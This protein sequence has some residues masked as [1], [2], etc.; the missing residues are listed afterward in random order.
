MKPR[1][2]LLDHLLGAALA[3]AYVALLLAGSADLAMSRDESFYVAAAQD[4]GRWMELF[5]EDRPAAMRK[6]AID[7]AWDYNHEHPGLVKGLFAISWR[8]HE[9][10]KEDGGD[11]LFPSDAAAFRFPGMLSAGLLLWLLY[12]FGARVFGRQAGAFAAVAYALMP[13]PFYHAH[14]D[15]FD[16]PIVLAIT[17]CVYAYWRA[18]TSRW[19]VIGVGLAWGLGL[20]TKHNSWVLPG[21]FLIH[22]AWMS[23]G[24][25]GMRKRGEHVPSRLSTRPWWM[26]SLTILGPPIFIAT[27]PWL[28]DLSTTLERFGWYAR[29]HLSHEYYNIAYFGTTYF[30]PPFPVA[31][32]FVLTLFTVPLTTLVL[33]AL[34][35]GQRLRALLPAPLARRVWPK[36]EAKADAAHTDVLLVGAMLAPMVMIALPSTP[37]FGATKHW[38]P[39]YPFLCLYAGLGFWRVA[40]L[41]RHG[42][43]KRL[44]AARH[45]ARLV[46]AGVLIAPLALETHHSHPFGL[47][48]YTVLAGGAPGAAD[49]GMNRQFWGFTTGSLVDFFEEELPDGGTV[50]LCDTTPGAWAMLHRDGRLPRNIRWAP[51]MARADYVMVHHELHFA[52]VDHQAWVAFGSTEP[53]HVLTYDGVPIIT[54]YENPRRRGRAR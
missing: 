30:E 3:T 42:L 40:H 45:L 48:H 24:V 51:S 36:G 8:L 35:L 5:L 32:P 14:L 41:F 44:P 7:E 4:Y 46:V 29:F 10:A 23:L 47:S 38:F 21:I 33:A 1:I 37:I 22:F 15:C 50:W 19:W 52:E 39:A 28:W 34:G 2:G 53:A 27:W 16:I 20:A 49:L 9:H 18:L 54:V 43:G 31:Y 6:E 25:R 26:I 17:F 11:G 13:R 12:I